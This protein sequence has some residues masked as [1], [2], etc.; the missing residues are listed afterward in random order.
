MRAYIPK[1]LWQATKEKIIAFLKTAKQ[2][3]AEDFSNFSTAVIG[4][5]AFKRITNYINQAKENEN[6]EI[7]FGGNYDD[8]KGY[9]IEPTII[10]TKDP[11]ST[12]MVEEIFG[13]VLTIFIYDDNTLTETL[14][15]VN[16]TSDYALTGAII[17]TDIYEIE[18]LKNILKNC[19]GNFYINDKCTGAVVGQQPF[20]RC[21]KI[22]YKRQSW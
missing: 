2:G 20:G 9:F 1:S 17:A 18:N 3:N 16:E 10:V 13:P 14:Q 15:L 11:K 7:I 12:T 6:N 22:W 8:T 21:K 5:D 19:A 4:K